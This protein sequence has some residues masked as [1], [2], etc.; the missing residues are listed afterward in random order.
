M[1][2][3]RG[4]KNLFQKCIQ[5]LT[6]CNFYLRLTQCPPLQPRFLFLTVFNG[7]YQIGLGKQ[8]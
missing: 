6:F 5:G 8:N 2:S 4:K 3:G 7:S 1:P